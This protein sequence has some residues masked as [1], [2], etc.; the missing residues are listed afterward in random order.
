[1]SQAQKREV[2]QAGARATTVGA[3]SGK[4]KARRGGSSRPT[5]GKGRVA[6]KAA[7]LSH[8][9]DMLT[10]RR[11]EEEAAR[12][13]AQGKIGGFLHLYIGQEAIAVGACAVLE[14]RDFIFQSYR[15]HGIALARGMRPHEAMAELF[16]R[17]TGCARG[18]GGSM[19]FYDPERNFLGG[20][21]IVGGHIPLATGTAFKSKYSQDGAVTVC[22]FGEGATNI[23]GFHE[24]LTLAGLWKLP[25]VFVCENNEYAMG[26]PMHRT[27]PVKDIATKAAGYGMPQDIFAG[28]DV[29]TVKERLGEAISRARRGEGPTLVEIKTYRF[30]GHSISDPAKYRSREELE[31]RKKNDPL[32]C[33]QAHLEAAGAASAEWEAL[34]GEVE[35]QIQ[36]AIAFADSSPPAQEAFMFSTVY[37]SEDAGHGTQG[38]A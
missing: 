5:G 26:T 16:G 10:I 7:L 15:D 12:G 29:L 6:D 4:D 31:A 19:H 11:F 22:F 35:A 37:A 13:Y 8:Y 3:T 30:R 24:A 27:S 32:L 33:V 23:S 34:H 9:R 20:Y 17:D 1:M 14:P 21:G 18:L 36:E 28:H 38:G 2:L 25:A